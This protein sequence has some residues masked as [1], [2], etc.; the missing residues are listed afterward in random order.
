MRTLSPF[1][2]A[3][4]EAQRHL[5]EEEPPLPSTSMTLLSTSAQL[6]EPLARQHAWRS[7]SISTT[8]WQIGKD[9]TTPPQLTKVAGS[10]ASATVLTDSHPRPRSLEPELDR[11]R[12]RALQRGAS[13]PIAIS[14]ATQTPEPVATGKCYLTPHPQLRYSDLPSQERLPEAASAL[15]KAVLGNADHSSSDDYDSEAMIVSALNDIRKIQVGS[16]TSSTKT[17]SDNDKTPPTQGTSLDA[18]DTAQ[19][20][21]AVDKSK[22][23]LER[24]EKE[25]AELRAELEI[26]SQKLAEMEEEKDRF[27]DE[28]IYDIMNKM[29]CGSSK[30]VE[31][32]RADSRSA[33]SQVLES[34]ERSDS[35]SDLR[36]RSLFVNFD[37]GSP[38]PARPPLNQIMVPQTKSPDALEASAKSA[39]LASQAA[40]VSLDGI[41]SCADLEL[42]GKEA[43]QALAQANED[44]EAATHDLA[45]LLSPALLH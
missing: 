42:E 19:S 35:K 22:P 29:C 9:M 13:K 16:A 36:E 11:E 26:A 39:P 43:M 34:N 1:H 21:D 38:S 5:A 17:C 44:L 7:H 40:A 6:S 8:T 15:R 18:G 23:H 37:I 41:Y 12:E 33:S 4:A 20:L 3:F 32:P 30:A 28:D 2:S 24:L 10:V 25:N 31:A 45:A 27:F 14:I